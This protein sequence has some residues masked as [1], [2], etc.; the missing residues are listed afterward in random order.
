ME[1]SRLAENLEAAGKE[2]DAEVCRRDLPELISLY[3][4]LGESLKRI[5][6]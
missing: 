6:D 2:E 1:L 3:K 5:L 4:E